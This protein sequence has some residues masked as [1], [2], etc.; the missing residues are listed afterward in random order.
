M[1]VVAFHAYLFT[2]YSKLLFYLDMIAGGKHDVL[3]SEYSLIKKKISCQYFLGSEIE[4]R[5][6]IRR[7]G[8]EIERRG[9]IKRVG[10]GVAEVVTAPRTWTQRQKQ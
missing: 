1:R 10:S 7:V 3:H 8:S 2:V 9:Y 5:A 4:R 6:C